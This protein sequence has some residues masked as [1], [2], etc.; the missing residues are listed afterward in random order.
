MQEMVINIKI[1]NNYNWHEAILEHLD[2]LLHADTPN[3]LI[4][5]RRHSL[6][7]LAK[8]ASWLCSN[9]NFPVA[10]QIYNTRFSDLINT[11]AKSAASLE[12]EQINDETSEPEDIDEDESEHVFEVVLDFCME[13]Y[14]W[15][16]E[17]YEWA[18]DLVSEWDLDDA[19]EINEELELGI[20][21]K[22]TEL[23]PLITA[24]TIV[25]SLNR[26]EELRDELREQLD[27]A[28]SNKSE[29]LSNDFNPLAAMIYENAQL[30]QL[31]LLQELCEGLATVERFDWSQDHFVNN[32]R[33]MATAVAKK[34]GTKKLTK[35][36]LKEIHRISK[37]ANAQP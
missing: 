22:P 4:S 24:G 35:T 21:H 7:W 8:A 6:F 17:N 31:K 13:E 20:T 30:Q 11:S 18:C 10:E 25:A 36:V 32:T 26:L 5:G 19:I 28:P 29:E 14:G 34:L 9:N 12:A 37:K 33:F 1:M 3:D 27:K 15:T 23:L 16:S 2:I